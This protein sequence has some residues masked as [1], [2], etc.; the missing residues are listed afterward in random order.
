MDTTTPRVF[1]TFALDFQ[2]QVADGMLAH[3]R[4]VEKMTAT[5]FDAARAGLELQRDLSFGLGK[6]WLD[7]VAPKATS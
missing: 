5:A 3:S 7:A 1:A 6:T 4:A 2:K